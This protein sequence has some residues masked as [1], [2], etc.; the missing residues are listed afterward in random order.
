MIFPICNKLMNNTMHFEQTKKFQFEECSK[1][2]N[3]TNRK[4]ISFEDILE[5]KLNE[6]KEV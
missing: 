5:E 6:I 3:K 2:N 4:R 1:C